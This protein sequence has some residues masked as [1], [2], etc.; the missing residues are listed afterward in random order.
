MKEKSSDTTL[1]S[2]AESGPR[3]V[4]GTH[5]E[6]IELTGEQSFE[7]FDVGQRLSIVR[8]TNDMHKEWIAAKKR[9]SEWEESMPAR[10]QS[11]SDI[12]VAGFTLRPNSE[13]AIVLMIDS[14]AT[15]PNGHYVFS[16]EVV[17]ARFA[18]TEKTIPSLG[19]VE[20]A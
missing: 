10:A 5:G 14:T 20:F 19:N 4:I 1:N 11:S 16:P 8:S 15:P 6:Q 12:Y 17:R 9:P 2:S 13:K 7:G 18:K 3:Q